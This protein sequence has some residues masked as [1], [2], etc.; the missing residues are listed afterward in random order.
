MRKSF[1]LNPLITGVG[2]DTYQWYISYSIHIL[3]NNIF[4]TLMLGYFQ[5][6]ST[7]KK[8][9]VNYDAIENIKIVGIPDP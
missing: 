2:T 7:R 8:V 5:E 6:K 3:K 1:F 4:Y 9:F